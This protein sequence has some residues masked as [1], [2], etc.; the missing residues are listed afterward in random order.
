MVSLCS[1]VY[2]MLPLLSDLWFW[3]LLLIGLFCVTL[4]FHYLTATKD[5]GFVHPHA[6]AWAGGIPGGV[7]VSVGQCWTC[8]VHPHLPPPPTPASQA[9]CGMRCASTARFRP[10]LS[11]SRR[12]MSKRTADAV[13]R[14]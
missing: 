3:D 1:F 8:K 7:P 12:K 4:Y 2:D 10:A 6:V 9:I 14:R 5:P 13:V 11:H